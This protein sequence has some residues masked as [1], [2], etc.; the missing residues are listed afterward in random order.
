[1]NYEDDGW[2]GSPPLLAVF[3]IVLGIL[4][5]FTIGYKVTHLDESQ[6]TTVVSP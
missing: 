3:L 5:F 4:V 6:S 2:F 1:M